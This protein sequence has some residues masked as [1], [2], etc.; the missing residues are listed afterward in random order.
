[1]FIYL[2]IQFTQTKFRE[3]NGTFCN[4]PIRTVGRTNRC[5]RVVGP[6]ACRMNIRVK[7][8]EK[9]G[10]PL[11]YLSVSNTIPARLIAAMA[12]SSSENASEFF[13]LTDSRFQPLF[14]LLEFS[15]I[16]RPRGFCYRGTLKPVVKPRRPVAIYTLR[17]H[18]D[19]AMLLRIAFVLLFSKSRTEI[20]RNVILLSTRTPGQPTARRVNANLQLFWSR[21]TDALHSKFICFCFSL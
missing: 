1:M 15:S 19:T 11:I 8:M 13:R 16:H 10:V 18:C 12:S 9:A 21:I 6:A 17:Y 14:F 20:H 2:C 4:G 7:A 5:S 3:N